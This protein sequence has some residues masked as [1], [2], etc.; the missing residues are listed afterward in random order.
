MTRQ[1]VLLIVLGVVALLAACGDEA[2]PPQEGPPLAE[3]APGVDPEVVRGFE[4]APVPPPVRFAESRL[5]Q[6][7]ASSG[8]FD[9]LPEASLP[10]LGALL[11]ALAVAKAEA[12][13][14]PGRSSGGP[15]GPFYEPT[16]EELRVAEVGRRIEAVVAAGP[17]AEVRAA[18]DAAGLGESGLEFKT[19][20][21]VTVKVFGTGY[22]EAVEVHPRTLALPE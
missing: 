11:E 9:G 15:A 7:A 16:P 5:R 21:T 2:P 10:A 3:G 20:V 6:E 19:F 14:H 12:G 4:E 8:V 17:V 22:V 1:L 18:W 13:A